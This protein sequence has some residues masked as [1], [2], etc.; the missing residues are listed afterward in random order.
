M[1]V[2]VAPGARYPTDAMKLWYAVE[3]HLARG[4]L[5]SAQTKKNQDR[6]I[7]PFHVFGVEIYG[8]IEAVILQTD[9]RSRLARPWRRF[10]G[11]LRFRS[12]A[13]QPSLLERA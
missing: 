12:A 11:F 13:P 8:C 7:D 5:L 4:V 10:F 1:R 2:R 9:R 6:L 3:H